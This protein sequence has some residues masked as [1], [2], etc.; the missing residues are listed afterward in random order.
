MLT[1]SVMVRKGA[2]L[3]PPYTGTYTGMYR[4]IPDPEPAGLVPGRYR[5][6]P[7]STGFFGAE[8]YRNQAQ[9]KANAHRRAQARR[10]LAVEVHY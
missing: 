2:G 10:S 5:N 1:V 6:L 8:T 7:V 9:R 3:S 4:A